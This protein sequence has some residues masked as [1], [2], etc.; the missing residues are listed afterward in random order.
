MRYEAKHKTIKNYT[1]NTTSR[2]N[3]SLSLAKKLQYNF[4]YRL[5]TNVGLNDSIIMGPSLYINLQHSDIL[6][7]LVNSQ[8]LQHILNENLKESAKVSIN[9]IHFSTK[10]YIVFKTG[11]KVT[12]QQ[13]E[14]IIYLNEEISNIYFICKEFEKVSLN[15]NYECYEVNTSYKA[16]TLKS[17]NAIEVL[18][19]RQHPVSVQV[20]VGNKNF[21]FR[22]K[23]F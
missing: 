15:R 23:P 21:R 14:K 22:A 10:L 17:I 19:E 1:K 3:L 2:K 20:V 4:A 16:D 11:N 12:L 5:L 18:K 7:Q 6:S 8:S 13:I 9:G